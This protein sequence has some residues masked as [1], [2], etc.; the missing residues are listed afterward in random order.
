MSVQRKDV[1]V[2]PI[3]R[4]GRKRGGGGKKKDLPLPKKGRKRGSTYGVERKE[5][6]AFEMELRR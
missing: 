4:G 2:H 3:P 5:K 1:G 6:S